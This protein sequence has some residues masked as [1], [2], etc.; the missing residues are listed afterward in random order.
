[1]IAVSRS[2][3]LACVVAALFG[4]ETLALPAGAH[5]ANGTVS[6]VQ[7]GK[8]L[9]I[10]N[11][12]G[13]ILNWQSFSVDAGETV[14]FIQQ[15]AQSAVL[16]RVVGQS[17]SVILGSLQ[18]NGR[19]FLINPNGVVFGQAARVD[20]AGL[21]ASSLNLG[22]ADFLAGR[23]SYQGGGSG[24]PVNNQG[25]I[26]AADGG[27]V[28][29]I[30]PDVN[31]SG[32]VTAANGDILLAAGHSVTIAPAASPDVR[33]QIS[34]PA[35][36]EAVNVGQLIARSGAVSVYGV[37]VTQ[38]GTAD[39]SSAVAGANG[40]IYLKAEKTLLAKAGSTTVADG[41]DITLTSAVLT[42]VENG[43]SVQADDGR[44]KLWSDGETHANGNFRARQGFL[45]T[46]GHSL[47]V[48]GITLDV[49]DGEWLLD[50]G[51]VTIT[52]AG[53]DC[54]AGGTCAVAG[55]ATN[56]NATTI[57][58]ALNN[59]TSVTIDTVAGAGGNGDILVNANIAKTA[60]GAATL[61]L[62]ADRYLAIGSGKS[63]AATTGALD[64]VLS[65]N[66]G[67]ATAAGGITLHSGSSVAT[68]GGTFSAS[69]SNFQL[70]SGASIN[71]GG[72]S[73]SIAANHA[74]GSTGLYLSGGTL[75]S[76]G[77]HISLSSANGAANA[78]QLHGS[79][80]AG[81]GYV[82]LTLPNGGTATTY[83]TS[84]KLVASGI[85]LLGGNAS[86]HIGGA[87]Q[88]VGWTGDSVN[89]PG[90]VVSSSAQ[91]GNPV[92]T[93][94]G[95]LTGTSTVYLYAGTPN[96][97]FVSGNGMNTDISVGSVG[98]TT[99]LSATTVY[100]TTAN[101]NIAQTQKITA[102]DLYASAYSIVQGNKVDLSLAA[103]NSVT[104]LM[105]S[106]AWCSSGGGCAV[107]P[108]PTPSFQFT[109]ATALKV[110]G[111]VDAG[112]GAAVIKTLTGNLTIQNVPT[113][114]T[115]KSS[116][117]GSAG[118]YANAIILVA[119]AT[120]AAD[121]INNNG[122]S[123][124][125][126]SGANARYLIYAKDAGSIV[127]GNLAAPG[128]SGSGNGG[129]ATYFGNA[130]HASPYNGGGLPAAPANAARPNAVILKNQPTLT[131]TANAAAR[132]YGDANPAFTYGVS[133]LVLGDTA[134]GVVSGSLSSA[135]SATS[136]VGSYAIT[137]SGFSSPNGYIISYT[138]AN[139]S[140]AQRPVSIAADAK[141]KVF[142]AA[143]PALTYQVSAGSV[144]NGD[145]L[146]LNRTAG[147][148][149]GA[150]AITLGANPNYNV[151]YTGN[152][153][154]IAAPPASG[155]A[156]AAGAT[157]TDV[158]RAVILTNRPDAALPSPVS[159]P[160]AKPV[161]PGDHENASKPA[162]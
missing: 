155:G 3:Q 40:R 46:S 110:G 116:L 52:S 18:S 70:V 132:N 98:A 68:N 115:I 96:V 17:P 66:R 99:G 56:V 67:T 74:S 121:F 150:Y 28:Y 92:L 51:D 79:I 85:E 120:T 114:G 145:V 30:A 112:K 53:V 142:G 23:H 19:V 44:I 140:V 109:N 144:A 103:G 14:R 47:N 118:N 65:A 11:T 49:K 71:T 87:P 76:G 126:A 97:A 63:I 154:S 37:N 160:D 151:S 153:L 82:T 138:G 25:R 73:L 143:D 36:G 7:S 105:A 135:A 77:G 45:E 75:Q 83:A 2:T 69:G 95:N 127:L 102:S 78:M 117:A 88:W 39:A 61:T 8:L 48:D 148:S 107:G 162:C 43:A 6:S 33:V 131:V 58:T 125:Q 93:V 113:L 152:S 86:Y 129:Y 31:N 136:N 134:S 57:A 141:S 128:Y 124:L 111:T 106:N 38:A 54:S 62:N 20:V 108:A 133:G 21:V 32:I 101:G 139:L 119:G 5:V 55:A 89:A 26:T 100:L 72:G 159:A 104:N 64:V 122:F 13:A 24:A 156:T 130:F 149:I 4:R 35:N 147:E 22:D 42:T 27:L 41:G 161:N 90:A 84:S 59:G 91:A 9:A 158:S 60:G 94:A 16:N 29:L 34:A 1:M 81:N 157:N 146:N 137:Q 50:P 10:T 12:P 123:P 80:D 15:S